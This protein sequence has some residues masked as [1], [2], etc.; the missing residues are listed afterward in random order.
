MNLIVFTGEQLPS[1]QL[2]PTAKEVKQAALDRAKA[3]TAIQDEIDQENATVALSELQMLIRGVEATRVELK[4]PLL[5]EG[6]KL[7]TLASSFVAELIT[8]ETGLKNI[9]ATYREGIRR[10]A[11][12]A[13][14]QRQ[15][16]L[17]RIAREQAEAQAKLVAET[18]RIEEAR[19]A[20][21]RAEQQR[22]AAAAAAANNEAERLE[23]ER[24]AKENR[25][26]A[27]AAAKAERARLEAEAARQAVLA[28]QQACQ[29]EALAVPAPIKPDGLV[30][31]SRWTFEV[32]NPNEVYKAHPD[33]CK[34]EVRRTPVN[35][36]ID[37][38]LRECPG[39]R[40]FE[41]FS[42]TTRK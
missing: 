11:A 38:G 41:D 15:A 14:A 26:L 18:R 34:V 9:I 25:A 5:K 21:I 8:A 2:A 35:E 1:C 17:Q 27:E 19:L 22:A 32:L 6:K 10:A 37:K 12:A 13:E 28:E 23:A 33:W 16:E 31:G 40:I 39:L 4:A 29:V 7:D 30:E 42:V 20:A 36:A 3:I 24:I